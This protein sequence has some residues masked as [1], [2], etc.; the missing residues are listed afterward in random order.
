MDFLQLASAASHSSASNWS[1]G[2]WCYWR[3][4]DALGVTPMS[5]SNGKGEILSRIVLAVTIKCI[6]SSAMT[7]LRVTV[8]WISLPRRTLNDIGL[9]KVMLKEF[10]FDLDLGVTMRC[11]VSFETFSE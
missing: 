2:R 10:L 1:S 11:N 3:P 8:R 4:D 6:V 7:V 5:Q 9:L